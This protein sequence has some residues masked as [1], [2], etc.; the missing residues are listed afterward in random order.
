MTGVQTC[1]LP[2]L[3][4]DAKGDI[5]KYKQNLGTALIR[6]GKKPKEVL[7]SGAVGKPQPPTT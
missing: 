4:E 7:K 3:L 6:E 2:I 5:E 1:A